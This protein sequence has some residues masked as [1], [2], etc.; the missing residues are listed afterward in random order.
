MIEIV[1][2][3]HG[4]SEGVQN[5]TLQ[6]HIDLPLTDSGRNHIKTLANYWSGTHQTFQKIITSPLKRA[7]ETG[8]IIASL[9]GVSDLEEDALWIERD[10]GE[11]EGADLQR[12]AEWYQNRHYPTAFE[13]IYETGETEWQVHLRAGKAIETLMKYPE[14]SYLVVSHGNVINAALHMLFGQLPGGRS[15]P[16]V[17]PLDPGC[18][19]KLSYHM[20]SAR[21]NLISFNDHTF[22]R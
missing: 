5:K 9:L 19:A 13:P 6:G 15:M 11:G 12:I 1:L 10:F 20:G 16:V 21:W 8:E 14:G 18:Y 7:R 2:L 3:R 22:L 4:E 17:F